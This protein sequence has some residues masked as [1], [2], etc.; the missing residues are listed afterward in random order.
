MIKIVSNTGYIYAIILWSTFTTG[1]IGQ[2]YDYKKWLFP[3]VDRKALDG[4]FN[5]DAQ[6]YSSESVFPQAIVLKQRNVSN[7]ISLFYNRFYNTRKFQKTEEYFFSNSFNIASGGPENNIKTQSFLTPRFYYAN[8]TK[9]YKASGNYFGY[10][11]LGSIQYSNYTY[12]D[13][14]NNKYLSGTLGIGLELGAGRIE[15]TIDLFNAQFLMDDLIA[16]GVLSEDLAEKKLFELGALMATN[17]NQRILD[18][19]RLRVNQL[20]NLG[21]WLMEQPEISQSNP[22]L[23]STILAD[24]WNYNYFNTRS[25]G[26]RKSVRLTPKVQYWKQYE[27]ELSALKYE[28]DLSSEI[29]YS[30]P[31]SQKSQFESAFIAGGTI[32]MDRFLGELGFDDPWFNYLY[33]SIFIKYGYFP[34]SRT[35]VST[36]GVLRGIYGKSNGGQLENN[37]L[38]QPAL[39][40]EFDYFLSYQLR[41]NAN[42][43]YYF[44]LRSENEFNFLSP[45]R[46]N[47]EIN[48]PHSSVSLND[49]RTNSFDFNIRLAYSFF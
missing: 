45:T 19:R 3:D 31:L 41:L 24:N 39:K 49:F 44:N 42:V 47:H 34:N 22:I 18:F 37:S 12:D 5:L 26:F 25:A 43:G 30:K 14:S 9:V 2:S 40:C 36:L 17:R 8:N 13:G 20:N 32:L 1:I 38:I 28:V 27:I 46:F 6:I 4:T 23:V 48:S 35:V 33:S 15:P 7:Y 29:Y 11:P 16:S 21:K 10:L